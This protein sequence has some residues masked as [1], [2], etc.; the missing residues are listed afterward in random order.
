M[1]FEARERD[2]LSLSD[3]IFD[4][5]IRPRVHFFPQYSFAEFA[6]AILPEHAEQDRLIEVFEVLGLS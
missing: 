4:S 1:P 5:P 6:L 3:E 2:G